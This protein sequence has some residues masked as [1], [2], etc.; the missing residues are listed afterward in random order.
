MTDDSFI[1][2]IDDMISMIFSSSLKEEKPQEKEEDGP[3]QKKIY[4]GPRSI[5]LYTESTGKRFRMTKEQKERGLSRD[6][7]FKE[8]MIELYGFIDF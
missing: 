4:E 7:A 6:D 3:K 5:H 8:S 1:K 2:K